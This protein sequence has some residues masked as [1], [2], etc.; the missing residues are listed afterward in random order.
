MSL[1]SVCECS[2]KI[3][4]FGGSF[5][6]IHNGHLHAAQAFIKELDLDLLL[7]VPVGEP[8]YKP[9]C[10][11]DFQHRY[12]MCILATENMF[13]SGVADTAGK[14]PGPSYTCDLLENFSGSEPCSKLFLLIASDVFSRLPSWKGIERI[15]ELATVGV[16]PR[17]GEA[18]ADILASSPARELAAKGARIHVIDEHMRDISSTVV[19]K[20]VS[21]GEPIADLVP[22]EVEEYIRA[23]GLYYQA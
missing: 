12:A 23:N 6:P 2:K 22:E 17:Y 8:F 3:G 11:A 10:T 7:F 4:I 21:A 14:Q 13:L 5:D 18:P 16:A 1:E 15:V 9:T 19:R 20:R